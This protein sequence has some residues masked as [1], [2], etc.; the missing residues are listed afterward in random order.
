MH[1]QYLICIIGLVLFCITQFR[2]DHQVS[3]DII[4]PTEP[5]IPDLQKEVPEAYGFSQQSFYNNATNTT[6]TRIEYAYPRGLYIDNTEHTGVKNAL[7]PFETRFYKQANDS[8]LRI[9]LSSEFNCQSESVS[10]RWEVKFKN[11]Q[12]NK[13]YSCIP[14][15]RLDYFKE[16]YGDYFQR[17]TIIGFCNKTTEGGGRRI[18]AGEYALVVEESQ[19]QNFVAEKWVGGTRPHGAIAYAAEGAPTFGSPYN[20]VLHAE[21][22][23]QAMDHQIFRFHGP[24]SSF[25]TSNPRTFW[26]MK[27]S[28]TSVLKFTV[29]DNFRC[30]TSVIY[31][32]NGYRS[33]LGSYVCNFELK[34]DGQS[35]DPKP[36]ILNH[37]MPDHGDFSIGKTFVG[38]CEDILIGNHT[39]TVEMSGSGIPSMGHFGAY[40]SY[41]V[42][43]Y[44][45]ADY[46]DTRKEFTSECASTVLRP[47]PLVCFPE[48]EPPNVCHM[49]CREWTFTKPST[50]SEQAITR[51]EYFD[52]FR[53]RQRIGNCQHNIGSWSNCQESGTPCTFELYINGNPCINPGP[54]KFE[55]HNEIDNHYL[56]T[57]MTY[58]GYCK[59]V[60]NTG[61]L[62]PGETYRINVKTTDHL[63]GG[64]QIGSLNGF[65]GRDPICR[66]CNYYCSN[67]GCIN[68]NPIRPYVGQG[69]PAYMD[70]TFFDPIHR[71]YCNSSETLYTGDIN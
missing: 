28:N 38:I 18:I 45:A 68:T 54:M 40:A 41:S 64:A 32:Q 29:F 53:C 63:F 44:E 19:M 31:A 17:E 26:F 34:I 69:T 67:S 20:H 23:T 62:Q 16:G 55:Y 37:E 36:L 27:A 5:N 57:T 11:V 6:C 9:I 52:H 42:E 56:K 24:V 13:T 8:I 14:P 22:I 10:C 58:V 71:Y 48:Q 30:H 1:L 35:C 61:T 39:V 43:E 50:A 3:A 70:V 51:I 4:P 65:V 47:F 46:S 7:L 59:E 60:N 15:I 2:K 21:E 12:T 25:H 66:D 49:P 33:T